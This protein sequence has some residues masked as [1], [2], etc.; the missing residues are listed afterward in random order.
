MG[1]STATV[2]RRASALPS[3]LSV[4]EDTALVTYAVSSSATA[5]VYA[6]AYKE[7]E[8]DDGEAL[9]E[10]ETSGTVYLHV[11]TEDETGNTSSSTFGPYETDTIA[12]VV[13]S[14]STVYHDGALEVVAEGSDDYSGVI[15]FTVE[16]NGDTGSLD[17]YAVDGAGNVS[18]PYVLDIPSGNFAVIVDEDMEN[19][20][21]K[22]SAEAT[23]GTSAA[24]EYT[25]DANPDTYYSEDDAAGTWS[26]DE[27]AEIPAEGDW[28]VHVLA[29]DS[30]G[31]VTAATLP[32]HG[33]QSQTAS[34]VPMSA[35]LEPGT[36]AAIAGMMVLSCIA[37]VIVRNVRV[38]S[39]ARRKR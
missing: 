39:G 1:A 12:P 14:A 26:F 27:V 13:T 11:N 16:P 38:K 34:P 10:S 9:I 32:Q 8:L 24:L 33:S 29:T 6:G 35:A 30:E 5:P 7:A 22:L 37:A 17:V 4:S 19:G 31:N 36:V 2:T 23:D 18:E 3:S 20:S 15:G 21:V 28:Y 25:V